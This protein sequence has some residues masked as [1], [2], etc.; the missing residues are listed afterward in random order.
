MARST[1][2]A[3]ILPEGRPLHT[4]ELDATIAA[5][6]KVMRDQSVGSVLVVERTGR[7]VGILSEQDIVRGVVAG[8]LEPSKTKVSDVMTTRVVTATPNTSVKQALETLARFSIRHLPIV[9]DNRPIGMVSIRDLLGCELKRYR[10]LAT[11]QGQVLRSLEHVHPGIT[12][13]RRDSSGRV[14]I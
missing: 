14:V 9:R 6:A 13:I 10:D 7:I 2:V 11:D 12:R 5:A 1:T 8:G 4:V 3:D